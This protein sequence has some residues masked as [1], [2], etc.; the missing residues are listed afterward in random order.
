MFNSNFIVVFIIINN[1]EFI[2]ILY[3]IYLVFDLEY[4]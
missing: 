4:S 2:N 3:Y 1:Y